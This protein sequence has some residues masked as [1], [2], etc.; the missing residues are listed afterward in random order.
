M[1]AQVYTGLPDTG[2]TR[3]AKMIS[4]HLGKEKTVWID[5][6][7]ASPYIYNPFLFAGVSDGTKLI[8]IDDCPIDFDYTILFTTVIVQGEFKFKIRVET[9]GS[10]PKEVLVD[11]IIITTE[12]LL[13]KWTD[14][15]SFN[16]L[17]EVI[18]FPLNLWTLD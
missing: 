4:E 12:R 1:K 13:P 5:G 15:Y 8:V 10:R 14:C 9:M 17:F 16:R 11:Q 7:H 3:V 2:K 18:E 6:R